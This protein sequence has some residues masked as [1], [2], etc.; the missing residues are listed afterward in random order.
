MTAIVLMSGITTEGKWGNYM[1]KNASNTKDQWV[2]LKNVGIRYEVD[3]ISSMMDQLNIP[4]L[5]KSSGS[6][7]Y[8]DIYMGASI[9]G[10]NIYVPA[11]RLKEAQEII[12]ISEPVESG[13]SVEDAIQPE[14]YQSGYIIRYR[15]LFKMLMIILF[16]VPSILGFIFI[17][18]Q[19]IRDLFK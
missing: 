15:H 17:I 6:G 1:L 5:K 11:S 13:I 16:I 7:D 10:Y 19:I 14:D 12:E 2:L 8:T 4:V 3:L 9:T 18:F